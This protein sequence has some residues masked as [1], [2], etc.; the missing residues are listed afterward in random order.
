VDDT[1]GTGTF[2]DFHRRLWLS[3]NKNLSNSLHRNCFYFGY[4]L[5]MLTA[6]DS[7]N[8]LP[9]F[10]FLSPASRHD[11]HGFLYNWFSMKQMLPQANVTKLILDS[12][13]DAMPYYEYCKAHGITPLIDLNWKCGRNVHLVLDDDPRLINHPPRGSKEWKLAFNARTSAERCNKRQKI[14]YKLEEADTVHL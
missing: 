1:P 11:S 13:H 7:V 2:Y 4:D 3:D 10:L 6:S 9:V 5:Y 8:D 14:D 12:A